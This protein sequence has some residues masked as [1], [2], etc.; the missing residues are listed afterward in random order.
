[1]QTAERNAPWTPPLQCMSEQERH[2][3]ISRPQTGGSMY[4]H[5]YRRGVGGCQG[6][7]LQ[8]CRH[9]RFQ[10]AFLT[11]PTGWRGRGGWCNSQI[12]WGRLVFLHPPPQ[13]RLVQLHA[14]FELQHQDSCLT[15]PT[16]QVPQRYLHLYSNLIT[17]RFLSWQCTAHLPIK[18]HTLLG[19][20]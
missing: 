4:P 19:L 2:M 6:G 3:I 5:V 16:L 10:K 9:E 13:G 14:G 18:N 8:L 11:F 15:P 12:S 7:I 17:T 1:M 20:S